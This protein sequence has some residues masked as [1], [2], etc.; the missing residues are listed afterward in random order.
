MQEKMGI[1]TGMYAFSSELFGHGKVRY[2]LG[3]GSGPT[4]IQRTCERLGIVLTEA[5]SERVLEW[6]KEESRLRKA[7]I[8]DVTFRHLVQK[9]KQL[10]AK[11]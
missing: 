4:A 10:D 6:V 2:L 11:A 8:S 7:T 5:E 1:D 9:A 3:K